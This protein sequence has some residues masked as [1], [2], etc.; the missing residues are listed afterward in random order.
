MSAVEERIVNLEEKVETQGQKIKIY[1]MLG[2]V[3][4][5]ALALAVLF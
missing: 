2:A 5:A 4:L 3:L 1:V